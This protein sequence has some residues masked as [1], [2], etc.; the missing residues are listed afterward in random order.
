MSVIIEVALV[1]YRAV[2]WSLPQLDSC[3]PATCR[4]HLMMQETHC[5]LLI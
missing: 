1:H 2:I 4:A 5:H 3:F